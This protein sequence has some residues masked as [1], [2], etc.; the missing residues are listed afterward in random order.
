LTLTSIARQITC[1]SFIHI[2]L[3]DFKNT[4]P[5]ASLVSLQ[6]LL[7]LQNQQ[8]LPRFIE[9]LPVKEMNRSGDTKRDN[10]DPSYAVL[11]NMP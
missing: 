5:L 7:A 4:S 11:R 6:I 10:T 8:A 9:N 1:I 3:N 2:A